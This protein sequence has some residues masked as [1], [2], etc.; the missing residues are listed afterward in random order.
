MKPYL[1]LIEDKPV[2]PVIY[3]KNRVVLSMPPIIN[4]KSQNSQSK[5]YMS[6]L[7]DHSKISL[8]TRNVFIESTALDLHKV[9]NLNVIAIQCFNTLTGEGKDRFGHSSLHVQSVLCRAV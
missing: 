7:G 4:S 5:Y 6:L 3:D 1:S 9:P 2:Y 8:G